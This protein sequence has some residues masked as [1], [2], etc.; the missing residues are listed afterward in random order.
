MFL[1][2][3]KLVDD[4]RPEAPPRGDGEH[5][6]RPV[7]AGEP[8]DEVGEGVGHRLEEDVRAAEGQRRSERVI[9]GLACQAGKQC[10]QLFSCHGENAVDRVHRC[11]PVRS[12]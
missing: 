8:G 11:Q 10:R 9:R 2:F 5:G 3:E 1:F 4:G 6:E 12:R 7:R